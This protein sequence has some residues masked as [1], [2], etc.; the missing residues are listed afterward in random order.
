MFVSAH[1]SGENVI[2]KFDDGEPWK[3]VLGPVFM[4]LNKADKGTNASLLWEDA[5][6]KVAAHF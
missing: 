3:K 4:Y 5:K 2:P 6:Q 1:Y